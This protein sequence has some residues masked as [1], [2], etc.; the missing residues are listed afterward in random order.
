MAPFVLH[1]NSPEKKGFQ[2]PLLL[3]AQCWPPGPHCEGLPWHSGSI[4]APS[5]SHSFQACR[6]GKSE[7]C[8]RHSAGGWESRLKHSPSQGLCF[9]VQRKP[10]DLETLIRKSLRGHLCQ[11]VLMRAL[12]HS[13]PP[14]PTPPLQ[15]TIMVTSTSFGV[16]KLAS[17][18]DIAT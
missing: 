2:G 5:L 15:Q 1:I 6:S 17:N 3:A 14:P 7:R 16:R 4:Q 9:S 18:A 11:L 12:P 10:K 8:A 13:Y